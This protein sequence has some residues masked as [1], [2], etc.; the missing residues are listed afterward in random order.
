M[1]VSS[2]SEKNQ[3]KVIES[4]S[5]GE[6]VWTQRIPR[7]RWTMARMLGFLPARSRFAGTPSLTI[8]FL[9]GILPMMRSNWRKNSPDREQLNRFIIALSSRRESVLS[10]KDDQS[11]SYDR[12]ARFHPR[13]ETRQLRCA[14][15]LAERTSVSRGPAW[16]SLCVTNRR[17][18]R[19]IVLFLFCSVGSP[20]T[21]LLIAA[22]IYRCR[23][24][25][26]R[27]RERERERREGPGLRFEFTVCKESMNCP[28]EFR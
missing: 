11:V 19:G 2:R 24:S 25:G 5:R 16:F 18:H 7:R 14:S 23:A 17:N 6:N 1:V 10:P 8:R 22:G 3:W 12:P 21:L 15:A 27:E 13:R 26:K 20:V 28:P 4:S 9:R